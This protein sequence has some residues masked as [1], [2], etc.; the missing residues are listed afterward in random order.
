MPSVV[1]H[2]HLDQYVPGKESLR[3]DY[4]LTTAHLNDV[5]R[6]DEN[7]ADLRLQT[8]GQHPL[9][10]RFGHLFLKPRVGV[11]DVPLHGN[12]VGHRAPNMANRN[13]ANRFKTRS[14]PHK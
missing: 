7:L 2:A 8:V 12:D 11:H 5:L 13:P 6:R 10:K 1:R 3:T 14:I 4:S 9:L